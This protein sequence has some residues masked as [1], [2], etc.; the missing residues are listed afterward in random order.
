MA[1]RLAFIVVM[2]MTVA[3]LPAATF[4]AGD[5]RVEID[6]GLRVTGMA[7]GGKTLPGQP[8]P[9]VTLVDA[10]RGQEETATAR[11]TADGWA[12]DFPASRATATLAVKGDARALHF[13]CD[14]KGADLPARGMLLRFSFPV[15]AIGWNWYDDMQTAKPIEA[16]KVYENVKPLRA[17][18]DLPEWKDKP[19][20][21]MGYS[22]E[23]YTT[24]LAGPVGLCLAV[25]LDK[26]CIFRTAY[27]GTT[28]RLDIVYDFALTPQSRKPNEVSFAFDLYSCEPQ[29]GMRAAL[30]KYY[31][32]YPEMFKVYV[33]KQGQW[34]A[35][36]RLSEID[37]ANEFWFGLQEGAPEP[38]YDDKIDV[39]ST[40][41]Y[42]HAG[43]WGNI[44]PP[45]DPEKDPLP[46]YDDQV[47]AVEKSFKAI[48]GQDGIYEKVG[49]RKPDGK[50]AVEKW[51]VYAHL[52]AQFNLDPELPWGDWLI[53]NTITR[54]ESVKKTRGGDL[55]GFY[56]DG[57]TAGLNYNPEHFK[58]HDAPILWDPVNKQP[59]INNFFS[60][61]EFARGT[62]E[63]LRPRGQITMMNGALGDSFYV[64]PW[65]DILGAETGLIIPRKDFNYIRT[66][67]YHKPFLTLLK[68][69]YEKQIDRPQMELFMKRCLAYGV[70]PGFFDWPPSGLGPGGQYWNHPRY[71]ERDRDL[72]RKYEPLC[73]TLATVGWEPITHARSS[74][75]QV[76]VERY[77]PD[78][79]GNVWLTVLNEQDRAQQTTLTVDAAALGMDTKAVRALEAISG[80]QVPL[81]VKEGRLVA[82]LDLPAQGV[83]ALQL[84]TPA[85]AAG[86]R[87]AHCAEVLQR[88]QVQRQVDAEKPPMLVHWRPSGKTYEREVVEGKTRLVFKCD[89]K[90]MSMRQW[91]MLFQSAPEPLT[92]TVRAAADNLVTNKDLKIRCRLAW[93]TPSYTHYEMV[94]FPIADGTYDFKDLN[95]EIKSEQALRSIEITPTV[96]GKATGT[97]RIASLT[98][99]DSSGKNCIVDPEFAQWYEPMPE[100]LRVPLAEAVDC[101]EVALTELQKQPDKL[102]TAA[103]RQKLAGVYGNIRQVREQIAK[104]GAENGARRVLR[105]L[106]TVEGNLGQVALIAYGIAPP[107]LTGPVTAAPGDTVRMTLATPKVAGVPVRTEITA[108]KLQVIPQAGGGSIIIPAN[109]Q[110]GE[111]IA[112]QGTVYLGKPGQEVAIGATHRVRV[113]QPL[114]VTLK[115]NGF[116][117]TTGAARVGIMLR[118]NRR[119]E[120]LATVQVRVPSGWNV[121]PLRD[122]KLAANSDTTVEAVIS[123]AGPAAAGQVEVAVSVTADKATAGGRLVMMYIP[124]EAN[125]LK[126]PGFEE[127]M[128]GWA[129]PGPQV[130][131]DDKVARSGQKSLRLD[132]PTRQASQVSQG[133]SLNQ[134]APGPILIQ[135]S[136]KAEGVEGLPAADYSLYVDI[137]YKDGTKLY[138][139]TYNFQTG[140]TDWQL[141]ELYIEPTKPIGS[142][143][144]NLLLRNRTGR[145][146]F[147]DVALMEDPA[148]KG[149]I[150][151]EATATVDSSFS[152]YTAAPV[153]DGVIIG[154]GLHWTQEA[155][156]SADNG[157]EHFIEL[158]FPAAV[159][160]SRGVIY[161]SLDAGMPRTSQEVQLQVWRDGAWQTLQ[162]LQRSKPAPQSEVKLAQP[163]TA[164]RFRVYQP[165][166][167]GPQDRP[168]L[169]WVREVELF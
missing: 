140:T 43:M 165:A 94:D 71:Y 150:A 26:P 111:E 1:L 17:Y 131:I 50:L 67:I 27:D 64:V 31:T 105:D 129:A 143:N 96:A 45:Y 46:P 141:G 84:A 39:L 62:A 59:Y 30:Q 82:A 106:E 166:G 164:D 161:W 70:Y 88:G 9:L 54:T 3:M 119:R 38:E 69:N 149:N 18:A 76:Y 85:G 112:L 101:I 60:S 159:T 14:L 155:W 8:G 152:G 73:R 115:S 72:F 124:R 16:G 35:F 134:K 86:W 133:V 41:Y 36:N 91:A 157:K 103:A 11:Q 117:S 10:A 162:T 74:N 116:D 153:N 169:M 61:V 56:Y 99:T 49:T 37:N 92:L 108:E 25:P 87:L 113:V 114:E 77:G 120:T 51:S 44:P 136:S 63:L 66:V 5:L 90:A 75:P 23:N 29:W 83:M 160:V 13:T 97:L 53:K 20:L 104:A 42:T 7:V 147:D 142:L 121:Q 145:A 118:N 32:M 148:R 24:V 107:S 130:A 123:P 126:N 125:L 132:N 98:L 138:G 52:L 79:T 135:A 167:K 34:M 81:Q 15:E 122:V 78:A 33:P 65:L 21:R 57:L 2:V 47:A 95:F 154:E 22:N 144:I 28:K 156:A 58:T 4:T 19:A 48:M 6:E 109:A 93:V 55:D 137:Y 102:T 158:K 127:G 146:W 110:P 68:G 139:Q 80:S 128:T 40:I 89:G 163:V 151:R 168:G 100:A 12:L